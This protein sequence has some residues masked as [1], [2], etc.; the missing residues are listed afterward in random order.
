M[1]AS[2]KT[3]ISSI[4]HE[5]TLGGKIICSHCSKTLERAEFWESEAL[6]LRNA[7]IDLQVRYDVLEREASVLNCRLQDFQSSANYWER[8][9]HNAM[10][11]AARESTFDA[12]FEHAS[13]SEENKN[14]LSWWLITQTNEW[15]DDENSNDFTKSVIINLEKEHRKNLNKVLG[16]LEYERQFWEYK[17]VRTQLAHF[18]TNNLLEKSFSDLFASCESVL[19]RI[20]G[21][22]CGG[23]AK[24][25]FEKKI[26][27]E[28]LTKRQ[29]AHHFLVD[30]SNK[31]QNVLIP[32]IKA[33]LSNL[34]SSF[35]SRKGVLPHEVR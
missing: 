34:A 16:I 19:K 7:Q 10:D 1:I 5:E 20:E 30:K 33:A 2:S 17:F 11:I 3:Q 8:Y 26:L 25:V 21:Y 28:E 6:K 31:I 15:H 35:F 13:K 18:A 12:I 24:H 22:F 14:K 29:Q 4:S 27:S 23:I 32:E 9:A